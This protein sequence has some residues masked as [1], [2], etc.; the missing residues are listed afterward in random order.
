MSDDSKATSQSQPDT[1]S[2]NSDATTNEKSVP[3]K[4][5]TSYGKSKRGIPPE[6]PETS[7]GKYMQGIPPEKPEASYRVVKETKD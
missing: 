1:T 4:P 5:E 3:E 7:Y 2:S 6:K